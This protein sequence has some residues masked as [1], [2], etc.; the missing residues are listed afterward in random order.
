MRTLALLGLLGLAGCQAGPRPLPATTAP[1]AAAPAGGE[2]ALESVRVE[3]AGMP[4]AT[5]SA[6]AS[7]EL[8][9]LR[10]AGVI[11]L[12]ARQ[13]DAEWAFAAGGTGASDVVDGVDVGIDVGQKQLVP[14]LGRKRMPPGPGRVKWFGGFRRD[15][16]YHAIVTGTGTPLSLRVVGGP[17]RGAITVSVFRLTPAPPA[18]GA[19]LE[20][21][22]V[23]GREK[24][25][26]RT[27]LRPAAGSVYL[28]QAAGELQV[29]GPGRMGDAEFHDYRADGSGDNEGEAGVDFGLGVDEPEIPAST[30]GP[31]HPQR[32]LKWGAF[33]TDHTYYMLYAGTGDAIGL[34][35][36]DSGGRSGI[37]KDNDGYLPL[38]VFRVP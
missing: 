23:P 36:H 27:A 15:H 26:V 37:Y 28:L 21:V 17:G 34:N 4:A 18:L 1:P 12:G 14:A 7:G 16:V 6:L 38:S 8:Y 32:R 19:P 30:T 29:G 3:A 25:A 2:P 11:D 24:V 9:L 5:R 33:R 13:L 35:Y 22:M 31:S 10:A 20:T